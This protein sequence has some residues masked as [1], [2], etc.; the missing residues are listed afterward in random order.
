MSLERRVRVLIVDDSALMRH[1]LGE[2]LGSSPEIEVVGTARD[3]THALQLMAERRPDVVTLD[4]EMPGISGLDVLPEILS[5]REVPVVMVSSQTT[6]GAEVTLEALDRGAVDYMAKPEKHQITGLREARDALV[7][8]ILAASKGRVRRPSSRPVGAVAA[9][10]ERPR[11]PQPTLAA[12]CVVIGISTGG[13]QTLTECF[14]ALMPPIPPL[15]V[16]QHMP[17][18]FTPV[19]ARRLDRCCRLPVVEASHGDRVK[20][21]SILI[22]PGS[23]HMTLIGSPPN[24]RVVLLDDKPVSGH[25]PSIDVLFRSAAQVFGAG[26]VGM[27]MTGMGRDGVDGCRMI[28]EAGGATFAQDEA[29][30]IIFGMNRIAIDEGVIGRQFAADELPELLGRFAF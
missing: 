14:A 15:L 25:R 3:G 12:H 5:V 9:D 11:R 24:V 4:V 22:A 18:Q 23:H 6:Q 21:D 10:S 8:K 7:S 19:F 16:V 1:L 28:L 30:S 26:A 29:S 2:L 20:P 13:P 17:E 27:L